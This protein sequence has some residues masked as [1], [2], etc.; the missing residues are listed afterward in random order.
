MISAFI[1][2]YRQVQGNHGKHYTV[3]QIEVFLSGKCHK[4][5]RRYRAFHN[6]HKQ[7]K[8]LIHTP[9]FPPKRVRNLNP[10][11]LE[12]RR[13]ALE[14]YLQVL[15][16]R[17][18]VPN[19]LLTFLSLPTVS[20]SSSVNSLNTLDDKVISHQPLMTFRP[21]PFLE[22]SGNDMLPDIVTRGVLL[23]FYSSEEN[24]KLVH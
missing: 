23:A 15:L 14:N 6:L 10:K 11:V 18:P 4:I 16:R 3:F 13:K 7:L 12:Q 21:N 8:N 24:N 5:E 17:K 9:E 19:H 2:G 22:Q 20:P 1:P